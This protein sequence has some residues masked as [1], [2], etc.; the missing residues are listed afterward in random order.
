ME[1]FRATAPN[2]NRLHPLR[3]LLILL[4]FILLGMS[5]GSMIAGAVIVA[6]AAAGGNTVTNAF[7]LLNHP[8]DFAGSWYL[9]MFV[10]G[11][12]HLFSFLVPCLL[13]LRFIEHRPAGDLNDR[14]LS[15][16]QALGVVVLLTIAFMPF[17]GLIIEWNR[18]M[19]LPDSLSGLENWMRQKEDQLSE[20][21]TFLTTFTTPWQLAIA[22]FVIGVIPAIGEEVLF[23]GLV[24]RKLQQ[25]FGNPHLAV[26]IAALIFSAIH[27]QFYGFIPRTLLGA[28]F[29]YLY[30]WSGNL[31]VPILAHFVNNGFTVLMV[32]LYRRQM[33]S[34]D[35][36]N[37]DSVP[38]TG[39]LFSLLLT[40]GF[41][42][43]F[44]RSNQLPSH[45]YV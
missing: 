32:W 12:S 20:L 31:W 22:I 8:K 13:Y 38:L 43:Y 11:I 28:L 15:T 45:P 40:V 33:V 35:I 25:W 7:D 16:V 29:G 10:Q 23:R 1:D 2:T 41:L 14:P 9:L 21:T 39:A 5:I 27:V 30:V 26:W 19:S 42:I 18:N 44:R 34:I 36:E 3:S 17:D 6:W 24:Q 4:G 37:T